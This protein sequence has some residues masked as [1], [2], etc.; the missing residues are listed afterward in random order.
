M[1]IWIFLLY[2]LLLSISGHAGPLT[3]AQAAYFKSVQSLIIVD[4][5]HGEKFQL[6][7]E[8]QL[9]EKIKKADPSFDCLFKEVEPSAEGPILEFLK[10]GDYLETVGLWISESSRKIKFPFANII[11]DWYLTKVS[12]IGFVTKGADVEWSSEIGQ[13]IIPLIK[14]YHEKPGAISEY[15]PLM[16]GERSRVMAGRLIVSMSEGVCKKIVL[17]VGEGH[18]EDLGFK[19]IQQYLKEAGISGGILF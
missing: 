8:I 11:P 14:M 7:Y 4:G 3:E 5:S 13:K 17:V 1:K 19:P 16:I 6:E 18:L 15:G 12:E 9:L 2:I 10:G